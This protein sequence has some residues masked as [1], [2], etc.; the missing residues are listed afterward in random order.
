MVLALASGKAERPNRNPETRLIFNT[1]G[2]HFNGT[3]RFTTIRHALFAVILQTKK[4]GKMRA[5]FKT[6]F[7]V[8]RSKEKGGTTR[9]S[10][11]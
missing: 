11:W 5:T 10:E 4:L 7:Y 6:L 2:F 1:S 8:N 3:A 9:L